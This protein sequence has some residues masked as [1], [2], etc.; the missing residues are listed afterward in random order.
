[1]VIV[2]YIRASEKYEWKWCDWPR[3]KHENIRLGI[4]RGGGYRREKY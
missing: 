3:Y 2:A 4:S 1:M